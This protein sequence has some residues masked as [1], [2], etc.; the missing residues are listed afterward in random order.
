MKKRIPKLLILFIVLLGTSF[1]AQ[2][3]LIGNKDAKTISKDSVKKVKSLEKELAIADSLAANKDKFKP[4]KKTARAS[5]YAN[6]F[7]GRRTAS[8]RVYDMNKLT[9]AHKTLPFGTKIRV[10]NISNGKTVV[11]EITDRGPYVRGREIDLSKKA[12]FTIASSSGAGYINVSLDI[13]QN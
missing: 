12:F 5:Y 4:Y 10:T 6:K 7:H 9:A 11:V 1:F 8:G 3:I 2:S 13:L